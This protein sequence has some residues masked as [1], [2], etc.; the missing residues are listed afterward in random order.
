MV[1][2]FVVDYYKNRKKNQAFKAFV[3]ELRDDH[4]RRV[5]L[6]ERDNYEKYRT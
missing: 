4:K 6:A 1:I 2:L 3:K 5:A